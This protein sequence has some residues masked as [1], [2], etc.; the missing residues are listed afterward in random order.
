MVYNKAQL[1]N[2]ETRAQE[3]EEREGEEREGEGWHP[4]RPSFYEKGVRCFQK[5]MSLKWPQRLIPRIFK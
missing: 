4:A 5:Y 3:G 1:P 2:Y